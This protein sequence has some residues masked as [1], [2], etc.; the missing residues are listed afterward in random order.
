MW[1][2]TLSDGFILDKLTLNGNNFVSKLEITPDMFEGKL[3]GVTI[4]KGND[5]EFDLNNLAG[6]HPHMRLIT[7]QK[8]GDEYYF[9]LEDI[10]A[11]EL[12]N[13]KQEA[14]IE[15]VAMMTGVEL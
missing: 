10:P 8:H 15:Y 5:D 4:E 2:I 14:N 7:I 6:I 1:K 13:A 11:D 12:R 9:V 3:S